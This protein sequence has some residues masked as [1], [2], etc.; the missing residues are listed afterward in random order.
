VAVTSA[1]AQYL[2]HSCRAEAYRSGPPTKELTEGVPMAQTP[3][4]E[5]SGSIYRPRVVLAGITPDDLA[6]AGRAPSTC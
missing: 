2:A 4:A 1:V 3:V 5:P 6:S